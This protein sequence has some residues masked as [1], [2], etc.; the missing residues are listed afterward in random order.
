MLVSNTEEE[1][2]DLLNERGVSLSSELHSFPLVLLIAI[3]EL[4]LEAFA[5]LFPLLQPF[6]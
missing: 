4:L 5:L 3:G 1:D 2:R 6:A